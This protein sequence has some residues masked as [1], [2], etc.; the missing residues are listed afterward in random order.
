MGGTINVTEVSDNQLT[1]V[2]RGAFGSTAAT[3]NTGA[4]V[5]LLITPANNYYFSADSN[6]TAGQIRGGGYNVS[7]GPV[8]L[9]T[10]GPQ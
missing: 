10:I 2:T 9:K 3:H 6:A 8:T 7:S 1:G 4:T 5:R